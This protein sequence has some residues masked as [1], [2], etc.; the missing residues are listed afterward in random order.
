MFTLGIHHYIEITALLTSVICWRKIKDSPLRWFVPYLAFIVFVELFGKYLASVKHTPNAWLYNLSVPIEYLFFGLLIWSAL[1]KLLYKRIVLALLNL[2]LFYVCY[3]LVLGNGIKIF[4]AGFL[5]AGS[6]LMVLF[7][8]LFFWELFE[9]PT[10]V[11]LLRLPMFWI[12][13]GL[14]LFNL[15]EFSYNLFAN[16]LF[17]KGDRAAVFFRQINNYLNLVLYVCISIGLLCR[18]ASPGTSV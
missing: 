7:S 14:F 18:K 11:S 4:N 16:L 6:G 17:K 10:E 15:G 12:V 13:A 9:R 3:E 5:Q 2:F 8:C 1:K